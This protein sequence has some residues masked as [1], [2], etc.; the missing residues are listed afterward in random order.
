[1]RDE[2]VGCEDVGVCNVA[3]IGPVEEVSV[4]TNLE[5]RAAL[6]EDLGK[7]RNCLAVTW[8]VGEIV[9]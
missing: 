1:L 6:L 9:S 8:S 7:A 5:V 4:V 2:L 3:D